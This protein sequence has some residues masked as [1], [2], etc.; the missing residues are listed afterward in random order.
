MACDTGADFPVWALLPK[1]ETNVSSF[2]TKYPEYDGRGTVIAILDSG[3][4]PGAKGLQKT[5]DG[6]P[7]IIEMMDATGSGDVDT[8]T[9]VT[10]VDGYIT[11]LTGRQLKI[12]S[13]W[14]NPTG[15]FHIGVKNAYELYPKSLKERICKERKEKHWDPF[16]KML[17]AGVSRKIQ[18]FSSQ[19]PNVLQLS[20]AQKLQK[21]ELDSQLEIL[22]GLEKKYNDTGPT[23]DCIVFHDG[24]KW[25]VAIDT[26]EN[27]DLENC[28]LL[29]P[30]SETHEFAMLTTADR[31]NYCVNVH[32]DGNLLEI[33]SNSTAHGTHVASIAAAYFPNE[34]DKNGVAPGAQII[35]IGIGDLRLGSMETGAALIRAFV[36]VISSHCDVINMSYG[37]HSHW[38]GGRIMELV[39]QVVDVHG[40]IMVSSAG[41]HG[42]ALSTVGTPPTMPS[43]SVIGVGAYVS[44]DMMLAE[45]SLREKL[46]GVGYTWTSRG[47]GS[48]GDL[49]VSICAPGGAITSVPNWTLR[50][51]QLMNGTSMSSPHAAG[52]I[53]V[54]LSGLKRKVISY[55]PYS[56][57]RAIENTALKVSTYEVFSMGHGL[58]Q[59]EKAFDHLV[60]Y[61]KCIERNIRFQVT[62][63]QKNG[64][65]LRET[66]HVH[67]PYVANISIEPIFLG[68]AFA[69]AESKINFQMNLKITCDATW[70]FVP[71]NLTLMYSV[72]SF[73]IRIDPSGLPVGEYFAMGKYYIKGFD[74]A[75]I[76]KGPVFHFPVTVLIS[77]KLNDGACWNVSSC[78]LPTGKVIRE[79]IEV[80]AGA[81]SAALRVASCDTKN[82]C[83]VVVHAVQIRPQMY[84]KAQEYYKML[85][86][87]PKEEY[88]CTLSVKEKLVLEV[89]LVPWWTS[90][91]SVVINYNISFR[92]LMP[93][94]SSVVMHGADGIH[95]VDVHSSLIYED[96]SPTAVLKSH[97]VVLR[98]VDSKINPLKSRD[99]IPIGRQVYELQLTYT[100]NVPKATEITPAFSLL[101]ELLYESE[102][103]SQL[104][105]LFD[106][107]KQLIATG[108]AYPSKYSVKI[109]KGDYTLKLQ[110]RHEERNL[111]EKM[112]DSP[113]LISSKLSSNL[114]FDIYDKLSQALVNGKKFSSHVV[115][116]GSTVPLFLAPIPTEKFP[117]NCL[118]GHYLTGSITFTKDDSVKKID[119]FPL[120]YIVP[121]LPKKAP[122]PKHGT[123]EK[124][125][126]EEF[127][128]E[129]KQLKL[130]WLAK[131]T[132]KISKCLFDEILTKEKDNLYPVLLARLQSLDKE[133]EKYPHCKRIK[134]HLLEIMKLA[135]QLLAFFNTNEILASLGS[136]NDKKESSIHKKY[137][138]EKNC[139]I[140]ALVKKGKAMCNYLTLK[141]C[142]DEEVVDTEEKSGD[143]SANEELSQADIANIKSM[144]DT[145]AVSTDKID[146]IYCELQKFVDMTDSKVVAF[147]EK[148]AMLHGHYGRALKLLKH[149]EKRNLD[150]EK[151]CIKLF[152]Q[153]D[154][155]HCATFF[156]RGLLVRFPL[157][158]RLF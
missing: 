154:W 19:N 113:L 89:V 3:V 81:T 128:E 43:N 99:V 63:E 141:P 148:Q 31:L 44:P 54:L 153:L 62:C 33:V 26:T 125:L 123:E 120:K 95:R 35:S 158:F 87:G 80:P 140:E 66:F 5:S 118:P 27:G 105:M 12:P 46:P 144:E 96:M 49:G 17:I 28:S 93:D 52:C 77:R 151:K 116:P 29:G 53:S 70:V 121:E 7:K 152:Q 101:S 68:D 59:V 71:A 9:I 47:P 142:T 126:E 11:G 149:D 18:E 92:G 13:T 16:H 147:T 37:E 109:E 133:Y 42:P 84:C 122:S 72:R 60:E 21:E 79:F 138:Q 55:S 65:Y 108:D 83:C 2:L 115:V 64:I 39:H 98:P 146:E 103:E 75:C 106:V 102:F 119:I 58:L 114:S 150:T 124:T 22:N 137:E 8:S 56:V 139:V 104:W 134:V 100:F 50:G 117:K 40:V 45:Y 51:A 145:L 78:T 91:E 143:Q 48:N 24:K 38:C 127:V 73:S 6:K 20:Q 10:A 132:G 23:Y 107:N 14:A 74:S 34:P 82:S 131:L 76:E 4:D 41:N 61:S 86:L 110:I 112:T 90:L 67:R 129:V 25:R 157:S 156:E 94:S 36:K 30:Y 88:L 15:R 155:S 1:R 69:D 130:S 97:V 135:D 32:E 111:L 57:R 85:R 136:K